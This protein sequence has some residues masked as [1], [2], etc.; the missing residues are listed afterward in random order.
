[1]LL[2]SYV[3]NINIESKPVND[4][5]III[6]YLVYYIIWSYDVFVIVL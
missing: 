2:V 1:M 4:L 3:C 6:L 5:I